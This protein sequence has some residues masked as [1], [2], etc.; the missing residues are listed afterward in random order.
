MTL[1]DKKS[2]NDDEG[3]QPAAERGRK[4][5]SPNHVINRR[6]KF[7][8][9]HNWTDKNKSQ[10]A[11][12]R[13]SEQRGRS[14]PSLQFVDK[15]PVA[16]VQRKMQ[17]MIN[18]SLRVRRQKTFQEKVNSQNSMSASKDVIQRITSGELISAGKIWKA[19]VWLGGEED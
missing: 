6:A 7:D 1:L 11:A 13:F 14:E 4:L 19:K 8:V 12:N 9:S 17:E 3:F 15:R 16:I 5:S 2:S 18:N 10:A